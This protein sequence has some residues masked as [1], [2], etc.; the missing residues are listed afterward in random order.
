M[1]DLVVYTTVNKHTD[2]NTMTSYLRHTF[3]PIHIL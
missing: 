3:T 2:T 1:Y